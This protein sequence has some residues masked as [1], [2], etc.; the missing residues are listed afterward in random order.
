VDVADH[1]G[2]FIRNRHCREITEEFR[3]NGAVGGEEQDGH[4]GPDWR[5]LF[6]A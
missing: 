5:P 2:G 6:L 4:S 1:R 3:G